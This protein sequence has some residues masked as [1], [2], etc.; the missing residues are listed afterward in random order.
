MAK[1]YESEIKW[2]PSDPISLDKEK[3]IKVLALIETLEES[4]DVQSV[5]GNFI[6]PEEL[7][8]DLDD[9]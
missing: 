7:T 1:A 5:F 9:Q 2:V 6:L 3:G 8:E 4:D